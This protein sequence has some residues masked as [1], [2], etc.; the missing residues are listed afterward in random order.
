MRLPFSLEQILV[1]Q[2]RLGDVV[3][4]GKT[5]LDLAHRRVEQ[6]GEAE[7]GGRADADGGRRVVRGVIGGA[8]RTGLGVGAFVVADERVA[9]VDSSTSSGISAT[10]R[11]APARARESR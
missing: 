8:R 5:D 11:S 1:G 10:G 7:R 2:R 9:L 6:H 4:P 3:A